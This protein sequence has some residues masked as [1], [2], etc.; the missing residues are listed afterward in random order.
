MRCFLRQRILFFGSAQTKRNNILCTRYTH[1]TFDDEELAAGMACIDFWRLPPMLR[2]F[3][4]PCVQFTEEII[5]KCPYTQCMCVFGVR[6]D[7]LF[8]FAESSRRDQRRVPCYLTLSM[9][10]VQGGLQDTRF[11]ILRRTTRASDNN[12]L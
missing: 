3:F 11:T 1:H 12:N 5:V 8:F 9:H 2:L 7:F 4:H 6:E 10:Y